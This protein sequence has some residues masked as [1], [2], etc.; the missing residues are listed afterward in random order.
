MSDLN[1][2]YQSLILDHSKSP[3]NYREMPGADGHAEGYNPLCGDQI[4]VWVKLDGDRIADVSFQ[5]QGCAISRASASLM[6]GAVKGKTVAEAQK[7]FD[8]FHALVTSGGSPAP[9]LG[10]LAALGGVAEFPIRVKCASLSWHALKAALQQKDGA[11]T[12]E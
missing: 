12:S 8:G 6:T 3:R 4:S 1:E 7:L 5:G 9:D 10:K 2:L 11:V